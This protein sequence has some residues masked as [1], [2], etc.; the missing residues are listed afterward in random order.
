MFLSLAHSY[1]TV[2]ISCVI[3]GQVTDLQ[4]F[5]FVRIIMKGE[6]STATKY[7][8]DHKVKCINAYFCMLD[9]LSSVS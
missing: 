2:K 9:L 7:V 5:S 3:L 4:F 6:T 1:D 8:M